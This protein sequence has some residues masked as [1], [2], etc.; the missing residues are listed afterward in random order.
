[1]V[2][3]ATI[4]VV[5]DEG[6]TLDAT[7][8]LLTAAGYR[9]VTCMSGQAALERIRSLRPDA[10][11]VDYR[12]PG[13]SGLDLLSELRATG[14]QEPVLLMTGHAD[15]DM[16]VKAVNLGVAEIIT[17]PFNGSR[18][19]AAVDRTRD[20]ILVI[21]FILPA[22]GVPGNGTSGGPRPTEV[23][24]IRCRDQEWHRLAGETEEAFI[25][26]AFIC[27]PSDEGSC[28]CPVLT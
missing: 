21:R 11:L 25:E 18:L 19:C 26:R 10:V 17:K 8:C 13:M 1:M 20:D 23:R 22:I 27:H 3:G 14:H 2:G 7:A 15:V 28:Q 24:R 4:L 16:A 5:D 12:M 9:A 6:L